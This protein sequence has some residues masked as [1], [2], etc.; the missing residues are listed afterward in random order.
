[1]SWICLVLK[2]NFMVEK[3]CHCKKLAS[4]QRSIFFGGGSSFFSGFGILTW[5]HITQR[6]KLPATKFANLPLY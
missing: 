6:K 3:L 1:M 5:K 2:F 4:S